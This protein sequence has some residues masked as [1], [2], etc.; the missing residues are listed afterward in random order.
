MR[1]LIVPWWSLALVIAV[2]L[3][4]GVAVGW[5]LGSLRARRFRAA[6]EDRAEE[7]T[8]QRWLRERQIEPVLEFLVL[9]GERITARDGRDFL[10][11]L[12]E[13][14][15]ALPRALTRDAYYGE[16]TRPLVD[17]TFVETALRAFFRAS[18]AA[19]NELVR[20]LLRRVW[21]ETMAAD[22]SP[23]TAMQTIDRTRLALQEYVIK[24]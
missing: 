12:Y 2:S 22:I 14:A 10:L 6:S 1:E 9:C 19:P 5:L 3:L 18:A 7:R 4:T 17:R 13:R 11:D 20:G 24:G 8:A 23:A 15:P 21:E 16:V